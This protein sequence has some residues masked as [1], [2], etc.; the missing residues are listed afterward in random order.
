MTRSLLAQALL[1]PL[2]TRLGQP[3]AAGDAKHRAKEVLQGLEGDV[4]VTADTVVVTY[5]N[6]PNAEFLRRQ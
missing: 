4:R 3:L 5:N 2:R 1:H 6:A